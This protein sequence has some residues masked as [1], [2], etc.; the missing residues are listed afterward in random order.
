MAF[1]SLCFLEL[2]LGM[3]IIKSTLSYFF[4]LQGLIHGANLIVADYGSLGVFFLGIIEEVFLPVPSSFTLM[5]AGFLFLPAYDGFLNVLWNAFIRI[6]IPGALGLVTGSFFFYF[7]AYVGGKPI[8]DTWGKWFGFSW[9]TVEDIEKKF[10]KKY[11]DE[12]VLFVLRAIP[13]LPNVAISAFCGAIRYPLKSFIVITFLGNVVRALIMA[14]FGW[15]A[16]EAY[17]LYA[18]RISRFEHIVFGGVFLF[19]VLIIFYP[20]IKRLIKKR[21]N[22]RKRE[23]LQAKKAQDSDRRDC[24]Q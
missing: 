24:S 9:E 8:I 18:E 6:A 2:V 7:F 22:S 15:W 19:F 17:V 20:A 5:I 3:W 23:F 12:V 10:T 1:S 13:L 21:L 16:G 14:F 4:M 11:A